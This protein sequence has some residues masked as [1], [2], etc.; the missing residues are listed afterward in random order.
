M[1]NYYAQDVT[2]K[3]NVPLTL[4]IGGCEAVKDLYEARGWG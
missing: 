4:K 2:R 3:C 1:M